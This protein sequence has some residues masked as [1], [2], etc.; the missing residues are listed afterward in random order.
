MPEEP[1]YQKQALVVKRDGDG[2]VGFILTEDP[3][4]H[5]GEYWY[6][7]QF[8]ATLLGMEIDDYYHLVCDLFDAMVRE[9]S[10]QRHWETADEKGRR[11][12]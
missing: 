6:G 7:V 10:D 9:L 8:G 5:A 4:R 12:V 11:G 3:A 1:R 2:T